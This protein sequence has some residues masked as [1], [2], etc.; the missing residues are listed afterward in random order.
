MKESNNTIRCAVYNADT[1]FEDKERIQ[2][3]WRS[4]QIQVV[5]ATIAFGILYRGYFKMP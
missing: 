4:G 2:K 3:A 5:V 1:D